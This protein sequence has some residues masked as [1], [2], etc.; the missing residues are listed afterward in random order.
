MAFAPHMDRLRHPVN[1]TGRSCRRAAPL[2]AL[3]ALAALPG[4]AF[5]E[6]PVIQRGHRVTQDL[7]QDI[8]PGVHSRADVQALLG[9]PTATSPFGGENWYYISSRTRQRPGRSLLVTDQQTVAVQFD[10]EGTVRDVRVLTEEDGQAVQMVSR[11]TPSPGTELSMMQQLFGNIG[12]FGPTPGQVDTPG[13][14]GTG[15]GR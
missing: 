3:L 14:T 4:C 6:A 8:T 15:S 7:L 10:G 2:L 9:S 13:G 5:F 1:A 11:Q 12:R